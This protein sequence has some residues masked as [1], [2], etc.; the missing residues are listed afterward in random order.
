[1]LRLTALRSWV[2]CVLICWFAISPASAFAS[3]SSS[4][5]TRLILRLNEDPTAHPASGQAPA[6]EARL[7]GIL[8][9]LDIEGV[10]LERSVDASLV[11]MRLVVP[12]SAQQAAELAHRLESSSEVMYAEPDVWVKPAFT[13]SDPLAELAKQWFH[14]ETFGIRA[15]EAWDLQRGAAGVVIA[16]LD[17]GIRT[18]EDLDPSR[19]LPGYD[20]I[21]VASISNDG[22]GRDADPSDP[23]DAVAVNE[24]GA[25]EPSEPSS[26]HGL[27]MAG[28]LTATADNSVGG[29]GLNHV[30][31]LLPVRVLGKCGGNFSD[32]LD[33][34]LWSA[35]LPVS[36][37]PANPTP[38][39]V[40]N[41]S[42][43]GLGV[44]N[45]AVQDAIDRAVAAGS[46]LVAAAG[47]EN[48][49]DIANVL[50]AGCNNVI[51]VA[52]TDRSGAV[53]SYSNIGS[54]V[55]L[56]A[57]GG[58]GGFTN[59]IYSTFN[60]GTTASGAD[61]YTYFTGTSAAAAQVSAAVSLMLSTKSGLTLGDVRQI[62]SQTAQPYTGG[63]PAGNCGAGRLD[64]F[65]ALQ[66]AQTTTPSNP[67]A[68][69][70]TG[71]GGGGGGG[72]GCVL[73]SGVIP[74]VDGAWW[75]VLL[76]LSGL[77]RRRQST[78]D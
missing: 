63:C 73:Q 58:G 75:L 50:P 47:N 12:A 35:G 6:T 49:T 17:T 74:R 11:V 24:C 46:I 31:R 41:M 37:V 61:S 3:P 71:G 39:K 20:F 54:R 44:C 15:Y 28:T 23:G 30:S 32:I 77:W 22:D 72:G 48:G 1:M 68:A 27:H 26:W 2:A 78:R 33:A 66:L 69:A 45:A 65:A 70:Q 62:L 51:A 64:M 43:A 59:G 8:R 76:F 55:L 42:F 5:V 18:H 9:S 53:A 60:T 21:S 36:G 16:L 7:N 57:P 40:I 13:P 25:G 4:P 14:F 38:A 52:A 10:V 34:I 19:V 29:A 56:S 67:P